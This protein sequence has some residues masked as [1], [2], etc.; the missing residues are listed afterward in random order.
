MAA[1]G[2]SP[3]LEDR[4]GGPSPDHPCG[5][6]EVSPGGKSNGALGCKTRV[7]TAGPVALQRKGPIFFWRLM[8]S[9]MLRVVQKVKDIQLAI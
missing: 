9:G 2:T 4:P 6:R 3:Y 5:R 7:I 1:R 8:N